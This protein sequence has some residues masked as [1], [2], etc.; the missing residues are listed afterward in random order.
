MSL[1]EKWR[2]L[3]L[4]AIEP[5]SGRSHLASDPLAWLFDSLISQSSIDQAARAII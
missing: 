1:V 4:L 3:T 5:R 2:Q